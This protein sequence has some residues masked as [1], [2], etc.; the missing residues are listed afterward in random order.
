M[1]KKAKYTE[2]MKTKSRTYYLDLK[3]ASNGTNYM[4]LTE[5]RKNKD[6]AFETVRLTVFQDDIAEFAAAISRLLSEA[7][8][9]SKSEDKTA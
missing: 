2:T 8:Q 5:S 6:G 3:V 7:T 9:T 4:Q 1:E